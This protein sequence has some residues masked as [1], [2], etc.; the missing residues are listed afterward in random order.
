[1]I[2][3]RICI[4]ALA[5]MSAFCLQATAKPEE[6]EAKVLMVLFFD[7]NCHK[8]CSMVRP[9]VAD[10]KKTYSDRVDFAEIDVTPAKLQE[11]KAE[12]KRLKIAGVLAD[13]VDVVPEVAIFNKKRKLCKELVGP[14]PTNVYETELKNVLKE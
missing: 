11:A 5:L 3:A 12:A 7:E 1:M 2:K 14:K 13:V 9:V 6:S 8:W 10:L 4:A